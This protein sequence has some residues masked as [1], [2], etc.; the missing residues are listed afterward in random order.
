MASSGGD[1]P[2][3]QQPQQQ[4]EAPPDYTQSADAAEGYTVNWFDIDLYDYYPMFFGESAPRSSVGSDVKDED[5][6]YLDSE[7]AK[8][9]YIQ[10]LLNSNDTTTHKHRFRTPLNEMAAVQ[11]NMFGDQVVTTIVIAG[12]TMIFI[13]V[14]A[15][16]FICCYLKSRRRHLLRERIAQLVESEKLLLPESMDTNS[17]Q[18]RQYPDH[19]RETVSPQPSNTIVVKSGKSGRNSREKTAS[20]LLKK[21]KQTA[22]QMSGNKKRGLPI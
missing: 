6:E 7:Q 13:V 19:R 11:S 8:T 16:M 4:P 21:L 22:R 17:H 3:Q 15:G 1:P 20:K 2:Q 12:M 10:L 9:E 18:Q 14:C 5:Y